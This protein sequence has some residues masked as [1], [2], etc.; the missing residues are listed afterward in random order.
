MTANEYSVWIIT[1]TI[2]LF[3]K[4]VEISFEVSP[5][6]SAFIWTNHQPFQMTASSPNK[7]I[8]ILTLC[9][10]I[11]STT[12]LIFPQYSFK[13]ETRVSLW[14]Q[15][16]SSLGVYPVSSQMCHA[17]IIVCTACQYPTCVLIE[18]ARYYNVWGIWCIAIFP[19]S[20]DKSLYYADYTHQWHTCNKEDY[21]SIIYIQ[22]IIPACFSAIGAFALRIHKWHP[23]HTAEWWVNW[24]KNQSTWSEH[25]RETPEEYLGNH[26]LG[27]WQVRCIWDC[28][29][30]CFEVW[31]LSMVSVTFCWTY[32]AEWL[33]VRS[34]QNQRV[35]VHKVQQLCD[36]VSDY[37]E[38]DCIWDGLKC[39]KNNYDPKTLLKEHR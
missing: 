15:P 12:A 9:I 17:L 39:N 23:L 4:Y 21:L 30:G 13:S 31:H 24:T 19:H 18:I 22:T 26:W 35:A 14:V 2:L 28:H 34:M 20:L 36:A 6:V 25:V 3:Y 11:P 7:P 29:L 38:L 16:I 1:K 37:A 5:G 32:N 10:L 33:S 8:L 27:K